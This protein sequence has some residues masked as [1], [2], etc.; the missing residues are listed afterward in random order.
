MKSALVIATGYDPEYLRIVEQL[1]L[2][3]IS[4][5]YYTTVL[6]LSQMMASP[7][8]TYHPKIL[9]W[10]GFESPAARFKEILQGHGS[11]VVD[12]KELSVEDCSLSP[13]GEHAL[14]D[15]ITSAMYTF[16]RTD[17]LDFNKGVLRKTKARLEREGINAYR[18][19]QTLISKSAPDIA[20]IP[21]GRFPAQR[22]AKVALAEAGVKIMHFEKGARK[23]FAFLRP[24]S[25]HEREVSQQD[26]IA[27]L[28]DIPDVEINNLADEWLFKR[29]PSE[30]SSNE[31]AASWV[32]R[33]PSALEA[34]PG[35]KKIIGFFTSS[36]DEFLHLGPEWQVHSWDSQKE[37]FHTL[38]THFEARGYQCVLRI[39]PNLSTKKHD[40][41][42]NELRNIR[43]LK[44]SH[45]SLV[46]IW[47]D[48]AT[49][50]YDILDRCDGVVVW[51]S[52]IGLEASARGIPTWTCAVTYY[53]MI[54][55][56]RAVL[57]I[58]DLNENWLSPWDVNSFGAKRFIA[59][60][61][62]RDIKVTTSISN[63]VPWD[64]SR[65]PF[66]VRLSAIPYSG[67]AL[68]YRQAIEATFDPWRH[69]S[70]K[71]NLKLLKTKFRRR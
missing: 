25:V 3:A 46:V 54:A 31:Y 12:G 62:L 13:S 16:F 47:H 71:T 61:V 2:D 49:S 42:I 6:D 28:V 52:T 36:Q 57:G 63:W 30:A 1:T 18:I 33:D 8:E 38:L 10:W 29:L 50:S 69:R 43:D 24:Y 64:V 34:L 17:K 14:Y 35:T 66:I 7:S 23:D 48:D 53:G 5:G 60:F 44:K 39:H 65:P 68:T 32:N 37:A 45:P 58:H 19:V 41:Y 11:T 51:D 40:S 22:M 26:A 9:R 4:K 27:L 67:G 59:Y 20:F 55:D 70:L 15:S 21:N 56:T